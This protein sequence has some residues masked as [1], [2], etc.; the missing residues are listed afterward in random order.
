MN[1]NDITYRQFEALKATNEIE[2]EEDRMIAIM[3]A[4]YGDDVIELSLSEFKQKASELSFLKD[5]IPTSI[6][7][8]G[9]NVNGREYY[10]DGMLGKIS[11]AQ[12]IDFQ[13]YLKKKDEAKSFSV[14]FI[15]KG[16]SYNDGYDMMEVFEDIQNMPIPIV[17]SASFF[18]KRQFEL[19][20]KIFQHYSMKQLKNQLKG[21]N[22]T[23]EMRKNIIQI[24]ESSN[25]LASY[26]LSSNFVK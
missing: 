14:F 17:M 7:V 20:T 8:K 13:N 3:Q 1:W 6:K 22:I 12:Y 24:A 19:F 25:S 11:T 21:A 9:V 2:N 10:F 18:F 16:H 5:E 4:I 15:P 26:L 23:K